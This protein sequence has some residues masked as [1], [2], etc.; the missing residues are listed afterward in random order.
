MLGAFRGRTG[1]TREGKSERQV[2]MFD[3]MSR[4]SMEITQTQMYEKTKM[5]KRN[6]REHMLK[7]IGLKARLKTRNLTKLELH[8]PISCRADICSQFNP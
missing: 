2:R 8:E 5:K 4:E 3:L 6:G 1:W 7:M